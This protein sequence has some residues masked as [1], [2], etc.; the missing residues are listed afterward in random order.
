MEVAESVI[1]QFKLRPKIHVSRI[2]HQQ[3]AVIH[4]RDTLINSC[5]L[6]HVC[7]VQIQFLFSVDFEAHQYF[8]PTIFHSKIIG[9]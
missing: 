8:Q 4:Q 3:L 2:T 7:H 9:G 1:T 6:I 5:T